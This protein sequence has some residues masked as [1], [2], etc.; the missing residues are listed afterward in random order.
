M[1]WCSSNV[2]NISSFSEFLWEFGFTISPALPLMS[3]KAW[4]VCL[5]WRKQLCNTWVLNKKRNGP[6]IRYIRQRPRW[7]WKNNQNNTIDEIAD[8]NKSPYEDMM[9]ITIGLFILLCLKS[10]EP[11]YSQCR[12]KPLKSTKDEYISLFFINARNNVSLLSK[13]SPSQRSMKYQWASLFWKLENLNFTT[14]KFLISFEDVRTRLNPAIVFLHR[15]LFF[16]WL[17]GVFETLNVRVQWSNKRI[18]KRLIDR[19]ISKLMAFY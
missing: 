10:T 14:M 1:L 16:L 7:L 3:P 18:L 2:K 17:M 12:Y 5:K 19:F 9:Q 15:V 11:S 13:D 4:R 8:S 6:Y